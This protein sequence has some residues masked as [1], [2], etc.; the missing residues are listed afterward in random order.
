MTFGRCLLYSAVSVLIAVID[1]LW[2][3][4]PSYP[5]VTPPES[6]RPDFDPGLVLRADIGRDWYIAYTNREGRKTRRRITV[7]SV[8]GEAH[9][10]YIQAFCH[11]R[12]D[13]RYFAIPA[14]RRA[15][16]IATGLQVP[17]GAAL[18][19]WLDL[20]A[21]DEEA[22]SRQS[23]QIAPVRV[24]ILTVGEDEPFEATLEAVTILPKEGTAFAYTRHCPVTDLDVQETLPTYCIHT[25]HTLAPGSRYRITD[26]WNYAEEL[27]LRAILAEV[28]AS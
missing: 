3:Q 9:P 11:L 23:V 28:T 6:K 25:I 17:Y 5:P 16:D 4:R 14:I 21:R 18:L 19:S 22:L 24:V 27:R 26:I 1:A 7:R 12:M 13:Q 8:H 10:R 15:V 2:P 20:A